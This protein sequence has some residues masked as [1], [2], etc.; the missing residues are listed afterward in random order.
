MKMAKPSEADFDATIE[1]LNACESV[2]SN[3]RDPESGDTL[4][5]H[6]AEIGVLDNYWK[7][8]SNSYARVLWAGKTAKPEIAK[9]LA[10]EPLVRELAAALVTFVEVSKH[11][12]KRW[13]SDEDS[14]VGKL[15]SAM[16]GHL[17]G[18]RDDITAIHAI[19]AKAKASL[20]DV[21]PIPNEYKPLAAAV[22]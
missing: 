1:F 15:L 6:E 12:L 3:G 17:T 5:D 4:S 7:H 21:Q 11:A 16:S 13:D 2:L 22:K 20:G 19:I 8:A 14:K 10:M 9:A 18:Y